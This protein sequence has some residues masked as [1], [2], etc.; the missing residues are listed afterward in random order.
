M[1]KVLIVEDSP[2]VRSAYVT[3][4]RD[5]HYQV[6]AASEGL[7]ALSLAKQKTYDIILMDIHLPHM[8]GIFLT[9]QLRK[10]KY[11]KEPVIIGVTADDN[12]NRHQLCLEAGM[13]DIMLKSASLNDILVCIK[14]HM[15]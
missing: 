6:E 11:L 3:F 1:L 8:D 14:K 9:T 5:H 4:F 15:S 7:E 2:V 10:E 13:N 12:P